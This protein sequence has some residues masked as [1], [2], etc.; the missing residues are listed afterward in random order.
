MADVT[1]SELAKVVG[2]DV[3]KLLSQVKDAGLPHKK[4]DEI[5]SNDDKNTLLQSLRGSHGE[6]EAQLLQ[7]RLR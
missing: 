6:G 1:I 2:V 3:D 5:I 4:A 7:A